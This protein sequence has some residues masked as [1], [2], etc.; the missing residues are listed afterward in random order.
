MSRGIRGGEYSVVLL[1][2]HF[3]L[4]DTTRDIHRC[5]VKDT[6]RWDIHRWSRWVWIFRDGVED[7]SKSCNHV[8]GGWVSMLGSAWEEERVSCW[9]ATSGDRRVAIGLSRENPGM[10]NSQGAVA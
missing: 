10:S 6:R 4:M 8:G 9:A 7:T 2:R 1:V 3:P 5:M